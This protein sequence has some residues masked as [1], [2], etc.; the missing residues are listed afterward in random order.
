MNE[1]NTEETSNEVGNMTDFFEIT[2]NAVG[3][4]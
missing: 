2:H 3:V 1:S 4:K